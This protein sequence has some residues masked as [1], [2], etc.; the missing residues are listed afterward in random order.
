MTFN[1]IPDDGRP[2]RI[3]RFATPF[4]ARLPDA[5]VVAVLDPKRNVLTVDRE[6]FDLLD[7]E[8]QDRILKT[9]NTYETVGA[10]RLFSRR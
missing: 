7:R 4:D 2:P 5:T 10:T 6:V 1:L 3:L 8:D 9:G